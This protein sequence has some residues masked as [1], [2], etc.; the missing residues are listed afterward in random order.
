M[1]LVSVNEFLWQEAAT[2]FDWLVEIDG[3][4]LGWM[5]IIPAEIIIR[6]I[7]MKCCCFICNID[8]K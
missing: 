7:D 3:L 5:E 2:G 6:I 1:T 4:V 8:L